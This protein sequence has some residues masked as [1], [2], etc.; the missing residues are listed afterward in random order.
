MKRFM[1][2]VLAIGLLVSLAGAAVAHPCGSRI[3]RRQAFQRERIFR[4]RMGGQLTRREAIR[5]RL[6]E[7][8]IRR[9][10]WRSRADGRI[11]MRE[12]MRINRALDRE[13]RGIYRLRHN[14]RSV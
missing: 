1:P 14:R 9:M 10:E 7:R 3:D 8:H 11:S 4:G 5:L 13:S 6:G 2:L 12:R